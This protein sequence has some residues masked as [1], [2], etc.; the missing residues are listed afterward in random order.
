MQRVQQVNPENPGVELKTLLDQ[1]HE[2]YG[3]VPDVALVMANSPA[4]LSS[5]LAFEKAMAKTSI[6]AKLTNQLKL[7]TSEANACSYCTSLLSAVAPQAGLTAADILAGRKADAEDRRTDTALKFAKDVLEEKGKVSDE[8]LARVKNAGFGNQEIV[9]IVA[10][11]VL[12]CFTNFLN[13]VA[14]TTLDI[15][16]AEDLDSCSIL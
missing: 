1:V 15:P 7:T 8:A 5:Y 14:Q 10:S 9:E 13:N 12:G 11:V 3:V 16:A 2:A 4:V 6:G